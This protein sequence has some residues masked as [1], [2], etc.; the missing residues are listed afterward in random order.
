MPRLGTMFTLTTYGTWLR[1]DRRCWV[2]DGRVL[3]PQPDLEAA[4]RRRMKYPPFYFNDADLLRVGTLLGESLRDRLAQPIWAL[5]V[6]SWHVHFV[7]GTSAQSSATIVKCAKEAVRYG[8]HLRRPVW[9]TGYD[10]RFC[11]DEA[12]LRVRIAYVERHNTQHGLP[13]RPWSWIESLDV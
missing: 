1:G 11:F 13:P 3:P 7:V 6:Q 5:T 8:L 2:D 4:D 10:E 12:A 9:T